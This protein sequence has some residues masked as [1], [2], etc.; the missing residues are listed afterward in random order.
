MS[1]IK[2]AVLATDLEPP[3]PAGTQ[4][5]EVIEGLSEEFEF[6][7]FA[8]KMDKKIVGKVKFIKVPVPLFKPLLF[9]YLVQY[10]LFARVFR[11]YKLKN[12]FDI[13]HAIEIT[14]PDAEV[15][16][17][18]Y[19][20][21]A[22]RDLLRSGTFKYR[23]WRQPYYKFLIY[24]GSKMEKRSLHSRYLKNVIVVSNGLK[25]N[26]VKYYAGCIKPEIIKVIPNI[27][28]LSRFSNC[29]QYRNEIRRHYNISDNVL[30]GLIVALGDW[31]RKGLGLL[32]DAIALNR[33]PRIKIMVVGGGPV[34]VYQNMCRERSVSENF[35][36]T[37]FQSELEKYYGASD[38]F[39]LPSAFEAFPLVVLEAAAAGLP[40]ITSKINGTEEII[41][42][43]SN[44]LFVERDHW[45]IAEKLNFI[46]NNQD[47]LKSFGQNIVK[48]A[49]MYTRGRIFDQYRKF[50]KEFV[51]S[52]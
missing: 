12:N 28:D 49:A 29:R 35:I 46:C 32:I 30:L 7:V 43:G 45:D 38:F 11:K 14:S 36:F 27:S 9:R 15:I 26:L 40:V 6:T 51:N 21:P 33:N 19:C 18:H 1:K 25:E 23:S 16:S 8:R 50:Y 41:E 22:A 39:I 3:H 4:M 44:G 5:M 24:V 20:G 47:K 10:A 13:I 17:M 52:K 48:K 34:S 31:Q 42:H 2:I 37:G